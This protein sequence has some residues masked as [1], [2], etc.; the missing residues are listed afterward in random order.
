[1]RYIPIDKTSIP[2]SFDVPIAGETYTFRVKYNAEEDY[3]TIDLLRGGDVVKLADKVTMGKPLFS[4]FTH[5]HVPLIPV[6]PEDVSEQETRVGWDQLE[7]T[8]FLFLAEDPDEAPDNP[9]EAE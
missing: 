4:N 6:V 1:M 2:Y 3:F 8:V 9:G 5:L 7:E